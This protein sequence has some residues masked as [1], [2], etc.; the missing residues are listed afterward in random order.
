MRVNTTGNSRKA[1]SADPM[2]AIA[3]EGLIAGKDGVLHLYA[4]TPKGPFRAMYVDPDNKQHRG[5]GRSISSAV[6]KAV[7]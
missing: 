3:V 1:L 4:L 7:A 2:E 5:E 6:K